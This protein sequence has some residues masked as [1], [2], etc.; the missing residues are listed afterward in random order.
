MAPYSSFGSASLHLMLMCCTSAEP[1]NHILSSSGGDMQPILPSE[2][3]HLTYNMKQVR[4]GDEILGF[5]FLHTIYR[6][7]SASLGTLSH[8]S[9]VLSEEDV[10]RWRYS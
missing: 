9:N 7:L 6:K 10:A 2:A 8:K 5:D 1:Q 3:L 4:N